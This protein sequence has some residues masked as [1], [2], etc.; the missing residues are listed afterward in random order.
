MFEITYTFAFKKAIDLIAQK[1]VLTLKEKIAL[2]RAIDKAYND[3]RN[4]AGDLGI[5]QDIF[6][7]HLDKPL[8]ASPEFV[9]ELW[10]KFFDRNSRAEQP[11]VKKLYEIYRKTFT[12]DWIPEDTFERAFDY[13]WSHF[14][15][16]AKGS[17]ALSEKYKDR[18]IFSLDGYVSPQDVR[19]YTEQYCK[20]ML[21]PLEG[22][23]ERGLCFKNEDVR[24]YRYVEPAMEWVLRNG[25]RWPVKDIRGEILPLDKTRMVF[26]GDAG[27]GKTTFMRFL[28]KE[29][30]RR[31]ILALYIHASEIE[32]ATLDHLRGLI[33]TKLDRGL[34]CA[35][36]GITEPRMNSL[37]EYLLKYRKIAFII[38]AY[39]QTEESRVSVVNRM[40][41]ES[42]GNCPFIVSTR[43]YSLKYL[44]ENVDGLQPAEIKKF[45]KE[46]LK[47]YFG[48][49]YGEAADLT[50]VSEGLINVPLLAKLIK[51]MLLDG[52]T[53]MIRN[54]T[55]LFEKFVRYLIDEQIE[56][57]MA[58]GITRNESEYDEMLECL[59][60]LSLKLLREGVKEKFR[61]EDVREFRSYLTLMQ[62]TQMLSMIKHV[63]DV[64]SDKWFRE[65][66]YSY[67]HPNFQEYFA[68]KQM[69]E[70][71]RRKNKNEL[72][73]STA[74]MKYEP[75]VGRFFCELVEKGV[76]RNS[77]EKVFQFWQKTL[78]ETENDWVR[79]YS[80]QVRDKLG[81]TKAK[82]ALD[83]IFVEENERL[84]DKETTDNMI[85][86]PA[87]RFL[88]GSYE[89]KDEWPVRLVEVDKFEI[90]EYPITNEEFI[91]FLREYK[92]LR[93][94]NGHEIIYLTYSKIKASEDTLFEIGKKYKGHPVTG[95]TWHGATGY[96]KWR[97]KKE[98]ITYC[99]P[100]E[101]EWEKATRGTDGRRYPW[102]DEFDKAKCN[103]SESG[104][105]TTTLV[106]KYQDGASPYGCYDM[107]GNVW[108][109]TNS[110]YNEEK[111]SKVLRG[112][113]WYFNYVDARCASR[114]RFLPG[115]RLID[116]GFRCARTITL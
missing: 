112:G 43:P 71:T 27:V 4:K 8:F 14:L 107:A 82:A 37:T 101:E 87:G 114:F 38:D 72:F 109:W 59:A 84:R 15:V 20:E 19:N 16:E 21:D 79:T 89:Y 47:E 90:G 56:N 3:L 70:L 93:D 7:H 50:K 96:C 26:Y 62:K 110:W 42:I 25:E 81:E 85:A 86:I 108:E 1:V 32:F 10:S 115:D 111:R 73:E 63:L 99:L 68:A 48:D 6:K 103:T 83:R 75:E 54:R 76:D 60:E 57:D 23:F 105:G 78:V 88:M 55:E 11:D 31:N 13:F 49:K 98:G 95:V 102:G 28:E 58:G 94:D 65:D 52:K 30:I 106:N 17:P 80:L 33:K 51:S 104:I 53:E 69:L 61:K 74:D 97:S 39:D 67:H 36:P 45:D 66:A 9:E 12:K 113:S 41:R 18:I 46:R 92:K 116:I 34:R 29:F 100:T 2:D 35:N 24:N 91:E 5:S 44:I 40:I 77:A 22:E 64:E